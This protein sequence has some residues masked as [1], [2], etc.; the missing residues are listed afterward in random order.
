[1]ALSKWPVIE[2]EVPTPTDEYVTS[3]LLLPSITSC[4]L[5]QRLSPGLVTSM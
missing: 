2:F 3:P 1:M 4:T 5:F